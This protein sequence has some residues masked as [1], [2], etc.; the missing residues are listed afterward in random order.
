MLPRE[1]ADGKAHTAVMSKSENRIDKR[2]DNR[3][4]TSVHS[5]G[6]LGTNRRQQAQRV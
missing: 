2:E 3:G 5:G 4:G 1:R 6:A